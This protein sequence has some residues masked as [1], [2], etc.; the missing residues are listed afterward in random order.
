MKRPRIKLIGIGFLVLLLGVDFAILRGMSWA[1]PAAES[2]SP[3]VAAFLLLPM[4][5]VLAVVLYRLRK[6]ERRTARATGFVLGGGIAT[7]AMFLA[8]WVDAGPWIDALRSLMAPVFDITLATLA[9]TLGNAAV[10]TMAARVLL[11]I[12]FELLLPFAFFALP[13]LAA[14]LLA[15]QI[16]RRLANA[17]GPALPLPANALP[18]AR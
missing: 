18:A 16:A 13:P 2:S 1:D 14:G 4:I 8:L 12:V 11:T 5:N 6:P 15:G 7:A 10:Q 3:E 9:R 17:R